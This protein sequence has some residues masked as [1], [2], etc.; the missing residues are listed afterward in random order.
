MPN[1][2]CV[3]TLSQLRDDRKSARLAEQHAKLGACERR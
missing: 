3:A 1:P 2:E